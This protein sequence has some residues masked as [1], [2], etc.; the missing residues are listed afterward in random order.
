MPVGT[1]AITRDNGV[2]ETKTRKS[3]KQFVEAAFLFTVND[4]ISAPIFP[5]QCICYLGISSK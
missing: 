1:N 2:L 4:L 3:R 5:I